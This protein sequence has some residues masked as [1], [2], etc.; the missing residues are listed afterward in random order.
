MKEFFP[1]GNSIFKPLGGKLRSQIELISLDYL[2]AYNRYHKRKYMFVQK[3]IFSL[4][5]PFIQSSMITRVYFTFLPNIFSITLR[6][7]LYCVTTKKPSFLC[8]INS[9]L[10]SLQFNQQHNKKL[11][12]SLQNITFCVK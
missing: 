7:V 5:R 6:L 1:K 2:D 8:R 10:S 11:F 9:L 12:F 3:K 4:K